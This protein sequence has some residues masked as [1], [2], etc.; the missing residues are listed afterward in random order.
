M[1][2]VHEAGTRPTA[3]D[4]GSDSKVHGPVCVEVVEGV[5]KGA[6][7]LLER[8]TLRVG[9]S[10]ACELRLTD[11]TV[12]RVHATIELRETDLRIKDAGSRNG[13]FHL[14]ARIDDACVPVGGTIRVGKTTLRFRAAKTSGPRESVQESLGELIG[15][16]AAMRRI[17]AAIEK[18]APSD[19]PV[20]LM[21]ET[22]VGKEAVARTIHALSPRASEPFTTFDC[23]AA[24][25]EMLESDLFGHVAGAF[26][27]AVAERP[28]AVERVKKGTL[29]LD[30]IDELPLALQP[31]LLRL[32]ESRTFRPVGGNEER[33][34]HGRVLAISR[35]DLQSAVRA[36]TFRDDLFF[37][38][39]VSEIQVPPLRERVEDIPLLA[40]RFAMQ[41]TGTAVKLSLT[42]SAHLMS[43]AW[44][45]N[46]RELRNA[47]ERTV[48]FG[49]EDAST[50]APVEQEGNFARAQK[51]VLAEF[52]R[53]F[54]RGLLE[55]CGGNLARAS[56][57]AGIARSHLYRL[58][59]R[60]GMNGDSDSK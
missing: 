49:D 38:L 41:R 50:T 47:I 9:S 34:F 24:S 27:G 55:R 52:E 29:C 21:G 4:S 10:R 18:L 11:P 36:G 33:S 58:L 12:S 57:E 39:A 13:T 45:G 3:Q 5:D 28:G 60:H 37:R 20:V 23:S 51:A 22:G 40:T 54:L 56:R 8:G 16:S 15:R 53:D 14:A 46:L 6:S 59:E 1:K 35:S 26:T 7:A 31:K 2:P 19:A 43:C 32:L 17:F 30:L 42:T 44:P 25:K 48:A